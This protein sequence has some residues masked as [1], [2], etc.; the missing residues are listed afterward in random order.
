VFV[1]TPSP[2]QAIRVSCNLPFIPASLAETVDSVRVRFKAPPRRTVPRLFLEYAAPQRGLRSLARGVPT[3]GFDV[4]HATIA[5]DFRFC[6]RFLQVFGKR[7]YSTITIYPRRCIALD[8]SDGASTVVYHRS[9]A[10]GETLFVSP[11]V[12]ATN[13]SYKAVEIERDYVPVDRIT[14]VRNGVEIPTPIHPIPFFER[15]RIQLSL[16][17]ASWISG[18]R[19]LLRRALHHLLMI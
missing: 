6:R 9:C 2:L 13:E 19:R 5:R 18:W 4:I 14:I 3:E 7:L 11:I 1:A 15:K 12:I 17:L 16:S 10:A 8:F